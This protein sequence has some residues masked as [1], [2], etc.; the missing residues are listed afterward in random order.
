MRAL[1]KL[2]TGCSVN[3][4]LN[5]IEALYARHMPR[6]SPRRNDSAQCRLSTDFA[7]VSP[8]ISLV[9]WTLSLCHD[10]CRPAQPG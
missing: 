8:G 3:S 10:R 4:S 2:L 9:Q 1:T 7:L 5:S 6:P